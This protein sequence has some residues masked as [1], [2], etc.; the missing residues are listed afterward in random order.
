VG[1]GEADEL[2]D[3]PGGDVVIGGWGLLSPLARIRHR[4]WLKLWNTTTV[5][6]AGSLVK[7]RRL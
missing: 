5:G 1:A 2:R 3:F 6:T 7:I 4:L